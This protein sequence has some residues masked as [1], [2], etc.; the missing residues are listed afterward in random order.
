GR[1]RR[2]PVQGIGPRCAARTRCRPPCHPPRPTPTCPIRALFPGPAPSVGYTARESMTEPALDLREGQRWPRLGIP[3]FTFADLHDPLRLADLTAAFDRDLQTADPELSARFDRHR[4]TPLSGPSEGD[5]LIEVSRHLSAFLGKLF[6]V[7]EEQTQLRAAAG[8][9]APIFRV[10]R[11]FVQRRVFKK[12]ASPRPA[13][14][15]FPVLD[16]AVQPL[17]AAAAARDPRASQA[18]ADPELVLALVI[19]TLLDASR[20]PE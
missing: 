13:A 17:L 19:D 5:L 6:R 2:G 9:D 20:A 11:E 10:K 18:P 12:G 3:G 16:D 7:T 1:A 8:R 4:K 14:D 15:E